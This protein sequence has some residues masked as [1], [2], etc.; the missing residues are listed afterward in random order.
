MRNLRQ[1]ALLCL[2][3]TFAVLFAVYVW[4]T[5]Y[6]YHSQGGRLV[7]VDRITGKMEQVPLRNAS[8]KTALDMLDEA[9]G[10]SR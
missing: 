9:F 8:R 5:R 7:R 6:W 3:L 1:I 10:K 2:L 4:P